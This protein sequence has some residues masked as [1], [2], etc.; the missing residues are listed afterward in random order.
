MPFVL[1]HMD[2]LRKLMFMINEIDIEEATN[3]D[4]QRVNEA[5]KLKDKLAIWLDERPEQ[6]LVSVDN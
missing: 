3:S 6:D 2:K 5:M 1:N 4:R